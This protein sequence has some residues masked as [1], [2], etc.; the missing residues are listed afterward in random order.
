MTTNG[1]TPNLM[2][3]AHVPSQQR[4]VASNPLRVTHTRRCI[5]KLHQVGSALGRAE[6]GPDAR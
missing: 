2:E 6:A 1:G 3:G 4:E 5:A